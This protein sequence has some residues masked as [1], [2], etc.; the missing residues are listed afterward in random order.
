MI[1][2]LRMCLPFLICI[3]YL[4][5]LVLFLLLLWIQWLFRERRYFKH[6]FI[7][8]TVYTNS[9]IQNFFMILLSLVTESVIS[10][11]SSYVILCWWYTLIICNGIMSS[12]PRA[13]SPWYIVWNE[14]AHFDGHSFNKQS[15]IGWLLHY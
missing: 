8:W 5:S 4:I 9:L 11:M 10:S 15:K 7:L 2:Q 12:C 6:M 13:K 3:I 14:T 1:N